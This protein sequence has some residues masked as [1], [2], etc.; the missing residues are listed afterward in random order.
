MRK[1]L[2]GLK[3]INL[4]KYQVPF[5]QVRLGMRDT[6]CGL[7][8]WYPAVVPSRGARQDFRAE[9]RIVSDAYF[10]SGWGSFRPSQELSLIQPSE[11]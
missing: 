9:T 3:R 2:S 1:G 4:R 8:S 10:I 5:L 11:K 7:L 6:V